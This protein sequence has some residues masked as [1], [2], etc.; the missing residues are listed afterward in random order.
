MKKKKK[1]GTLCGKE[2]Q[3]GVEMC[4]TVRFTSVS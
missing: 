3:T 4:S 1:L 2:K